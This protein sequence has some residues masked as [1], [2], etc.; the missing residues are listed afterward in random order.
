MAGSKPLDTFTLLERLAASGVDFVMVGGLAA[1]TL[2][3]AVTTDDL[4]VCAPLTGD[5]PKSIIRSLSDAHP[6]CRMRP[7]LL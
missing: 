1:I 4:D 5:N 6:R 2:G 3:S 7:D